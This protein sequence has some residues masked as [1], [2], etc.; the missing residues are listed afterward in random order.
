MAT[1]KK[2]SAPRKA[3]VKKKPI[4][5]RPTIKR[6]QFAATPE[7]VVSQSSGNPLVW[8]LLIL[9]VLVLGWLYW[10]THQAAAPTP[11]SPTAI[12][13]DGSKEAGTPPQARSIAPAGAETAAKPAAPA[14]AAVRRATAGDAAPVPANP[15]AEAGAP[16]LT[17]DRSLGQA[18]SVRCWRAD[19]ASATLDVFAPKNRKVRSLKS[20]A[21]KAGMVEV[22]WDGKD[23][24]GQKVPAGLYF[25]RPSQKDAQSIR[26]VW[27]KG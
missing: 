19:G 1:K 2:K 4:A 18:L 14:N 5:R 15:S 24:Q 17:F 7:P 21:G 23:E 8:V 12:A 11:P 27:V 22:S 6:P 9:S 10:R 16:S 3:S 26:D 20:E 25:L 13:A